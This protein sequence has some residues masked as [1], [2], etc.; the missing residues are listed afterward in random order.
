[1][2]FKTAYPTDPSVRDAPIIATDFGCV[3]GFNETMITNSSE[4]LVLT[5]IL[6]Y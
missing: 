6:G 5:K 1:M 4:D 3:N 2:F